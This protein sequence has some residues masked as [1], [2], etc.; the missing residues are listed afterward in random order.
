MQGSLVVSGGREFLAGLDELLLELRHGPIRGGSASG[1]EQIASARD[2]F[3]V[4]AKDFPQPPLG[5]IAPY[6]VTDGRR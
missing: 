4:A 1:Q 5:A 2:D 6:R 3:L